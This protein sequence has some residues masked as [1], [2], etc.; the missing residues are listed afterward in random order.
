VTTLDGKA[1]DAAA[2]RGKKALFLFFWSADNESSVKELETLKE[3]YFEHRERLEIVSVNLDSADNR[4]KVDAV[5]KDKKMKWPQL[6]EG[7]GIKSETAA[8]I[9][10]RGAPN[11]ALIDKAGMLVLP[12][13][14]AW[15]LVGALKAMGFKF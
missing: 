1:F 12:R 2:L 11:G 13:A 14:R 4:A 6:V 5:L 10:V 9:N 8:R 15:Q 7:V 3:I